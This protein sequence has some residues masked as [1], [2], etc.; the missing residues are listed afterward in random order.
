MLLTEKY[1]DVERYALSQVW[2][3]KDGT[4]IL[5]LVIDP[6]SKLRSTNKERNVRGKKVT[7]RSQNKTLSDKLVIFT[8]PTS[9]IAYQIDLD[10]N[11]SMSIKDMRNREAGYLF[12]V[13]TSFMEKVNRQ[14]TDHNSN[15]W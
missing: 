2:M 7:L 1:N 4:A 8:D 10:S 5:I 13:T 12:S 15:N 14:L 3:M 6:I 11:I 9:D